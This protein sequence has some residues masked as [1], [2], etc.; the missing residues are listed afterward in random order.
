M[1]NWIFLL[2]PITVFS[3]ITPWIAMPIITMLWAIFTEGKILHKTLGSFIMVYIYWLVYAGVL[4]FQNQHILSTRM[5][6][7]FS[8]QNS[9]LLLVLTGLVGG[10]T[11]A[12]AAWSGSLIQQVVYKSEQK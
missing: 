8:I 4:D 9:I 2:V 6:Q 1:K 10:I 11:A 7:L 12:L 3:W 5:A